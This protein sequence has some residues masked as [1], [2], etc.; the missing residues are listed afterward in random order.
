MKCR[1]IGLCHAR[2]RV[3]TSSPRH[4]SSR[5]A[6]QPYC[7]VFPCHVHVRG[8]YNW[9]VKHP[10]P[11]GRNLFARPFNQ[12]IF[13]NVTDENMDVFKGADTLEADPIFEPKHMRRRIRES[14][15]PSQSVHK[16]LLHKGVDQG[17]RLICQM[18]FPGLHGDWGTQPHDQMGN[19]RSEPIGPVIAENLVVLGIGKG[20]R[21]FE[22]RQ[23]V[24]NRI[25]AVSGTR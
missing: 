10:G 18:T 17:S 8:C 1:L 11:I 25:S 4:L 16:G 21:V 13:G 20:A 5:F 6:T 7:K 14:R 24:D 3:L 9:S 15:F 23:R 22:G 2:H 12:N 19:T